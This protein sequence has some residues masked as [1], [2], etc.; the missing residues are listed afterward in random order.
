MAKNMIESAIRNVA[1]NGLAVKYRLPQY[2]KEG[3]KHN[4]EYKKVL[5]HKKV[6]EEIVAFADS[7][8]D[9]PFYFILSVG[10]SKGAYKMSEFEK[11]YKAF[12]GDEVE[13]VAKMG[14]A[15]YEYNGQGG[16]KMSDV[17]IRLIMK[18]Y[19][20]VSH[21]YDT[22]MTD[23]AKSKVFGKNLGSREMDYKTLCTNLGIKVNGA[24]DKEIK[25]LAKVA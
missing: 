18:Y 4:E 1:T 14:K 19:E 9:I 8:K 20:N 2:K 24:E 22:F 25:E 13:M 21:D 16:R 11:G 3:T 23:L 10:V 12:K 15:Y 6:C 17:A 5:Q 7:H